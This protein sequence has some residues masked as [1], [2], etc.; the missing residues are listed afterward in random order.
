MANFNEWLTRRDEAFIQSRFDLAMDKMAGRELYEKMDELDGVVKE[1]GNMVGQLTRVKDPS[2]VKKITSTLSTLAKTADDGFDHPDQVSLGTAELKDAIEALKSA[3]KGMPNPA[4]GKDVGNVQN[5][6]DRV[7]RGLKG[8]RSVA[9]HNYAGKHFT[10]ARY[11][12]PDEPEQEDMRRAR[13]DFS[14][15]AEFK[16]NPKFSPTSPL[17]ADRLR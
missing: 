12:R 5:L 1:L 11:A 2:L 17:Y 9:A 4:S 8:A 15:A 10:K 16:R 13:D 14:R 3:E 6:V 7:L